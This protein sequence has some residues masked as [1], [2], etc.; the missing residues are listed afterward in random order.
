[1]ASCFLPLP[2]GTGL[3]EISFIFL[4]GMMVGDS[5]VW[6]LLAWRI[7]SYYMILVH[8]FSHELIHIVKNMVKNKKRREL[9]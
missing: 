4:F 9:K 1:M 5:I 8:G 2:G 3:M 7:L 6:A